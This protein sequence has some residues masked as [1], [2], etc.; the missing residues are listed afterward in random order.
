MVTV[1]TKHHQAATL[2]LRGDELVRNGRHREPYVPKA[3][4]EA[5]RAAEHLRPALRAADT[6]ELAERL[7]VR[8]LVAIVGARLI[9][10]EWPSGVTVV[11]TG[12]LLHALRSLP[13][14]L[15]PADVAAVYAIARRST[16]WTSPTR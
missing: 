5:Q 10:Q 15:D 8:S 16:T 14:A 2:T 3:R 13:A 1:N 9:V 6:P 7:V 4:R 12:Q 11:M